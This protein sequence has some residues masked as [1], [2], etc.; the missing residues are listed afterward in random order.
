MG[1]APRLAGCS[2]RQLTR[3]SEYASYDLVFV[4]DRP[5]GSGPITAFTLCSQQLLAG[6]FP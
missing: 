2:K 5:S 1:D 4:F 3:V 6:A